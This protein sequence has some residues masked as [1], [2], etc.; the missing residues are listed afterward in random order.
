MKQFSLMLMVGM[1]ISLPPVSLS[2]QAQSSAPAEVGLLRDGDRVVLLGNAF[3]ER[4]QRF[5]YLETE[6]IR[7]A[8]QLDL[9]FRN[10][11]WSGDTVAGDAW[12]YSDS[13]PDHSIRAEVRT[14]LIREQ[15]PDVII[16]GFGGMEAFEGTGEVPSFRAGM[17]ELLDE[18]A[19]LNARVILMTSPPQDPKRSGNADRYNNSL[20]EYMNVVR[21]IA[22][23]RELPVIDL[24]QE[25]TRLYN[26]R[27][28]VHLSENGM[29][30][31]EQGYRE[32]SKLFG[33]AM[34]MP[35]APW[36]VSVDARWAEM[37]TVGTQPGEVEQDN[38]RLS[39]SVQDR[40][41][42]RS[43]GD[44]PLRSDPN[45]IFPSTRTLRITGLRDGRYTLYADGVEMLTASDK[46][47]EAGIDVNFG[48][49]FQ[50]AEQLRQ[51]VIEKNR[52]F[53]NQWRP[54][55]EVY[56]R[57]FRQREQGRNTVE[58]PLF[59]PLIGKKESDIARLK[60]AER[61]FYHLIPAAP[62]SRRGPETVPDPAVEKELATFNVAEGFEVT[63]FASEPLIQNPISINWDAQGRLWVS[64]SPIYPMIKPGQK[65]S[66]K[67]VIL[68]DLDQDGRADQST[69]FADGL[70]VPTAVLPGDGGAYVANS[71]ELLHMRDT[72]GDGK[73]DESRVILSGFGTEDTHQILHTF[74]RGP[75]GQMYFN[76]SVLIHS[77]IE[78]PWG[79]KHLDG[80]GIWQFDSKE[81][82]LDVYT[83]G[84]VNPWGMQF[85]RWGQ[86]FATD[87]AHGEGIYYAFPGAA[88]FWAA[89]VERILIGMNPGQPKECGLEILSG[90]AIPDAWQGRLVTSDFRAH[91]L[92]S[93]ELSDSGSGYFSEQKE[94]LLTSDHVGF[95]PVDL[96]MGPDGALY[97]CD[98]YNPIINHGEVDFRDPRRDTQH[99][100]I[101][102]I[103]AKDRDA[104]PNPNL[105]NADANQLVKSLASP[106][107]WTRDMA[108]RQLREMNREEVVKAVENW[109]TSTDQNGLESGHKRLEALWVYQSQQAVPTDFLKELL[110]ISD[111]RIRAASVRVLSETRDEHA[112]S[113]ALLADAVIDEHP[114]VRLEAVNALRAVGTLPAF[115]T[116]LHALD[117]PVDTY[118]DYAL[119]TTVREL[120]PVWLPALEAGRTNFGGDAARIAFVLSASGK[121]TVLDPL[122]ERYQ[123]G[124]LDGRI[125]DQV[126]RLM[127]IAGTPEQLRLLFDEAMA[128]ED[129]ATRDRL[130]NL[131]ID[132][133]R[134]RSMQPSGE[135]QSLTD[136]LE[137]SQA[138][139][140]L[141]GM[142]QLEPARE[143]VTSLARNA[144]GSPGMQSAAIAA[145]ARFGGENSAETLASLVK[146][147]QPDEIRA[148]ALTA[149]TS[150]NVQQA[151]EMATSLLAEMPPATAETVFDAFLGQSTG[152]QALATALSGKRIPESTASI[153][154]NKSASLGERTTVLVEALRTAGGQGRSRAELG[155]DAIAELMKQ[156]TSQGDPHRGEQ[157]Y[158]RE[159]MNCLKCH[160][161]GGAGGRVGP[162]MLSLGASAPLDY[163][164]ESLINPSAKIKES[165]E[166][167]LVLLDDGQVLSGMVVG[168]VGDHFL[169]RDANNVVKKV[170][171]DSVDQKVTQPV[172]LM[173]PGL[174]DPLTDAEFV[175]LVRFLSELGKTPDFKVP[176]VETVRVWQ[177]LSS[178]EP[179]PSASALHG[180][181][182]PGVWQTTYSLVRGPLPLANLSRVQIGGESAV[183]VRFGVDV[184]QAGQVQWNI[185]GTSAATV[186]ATID[187]KQIDISGG[188]IRTELT[189]GPHEV[190][191]VIP[192]KNAGEFL[193]I[194]RREVPGSTAQTTFQLE[195]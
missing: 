56:L 18:L 179:I 111:F 34:G 36:E 13:H 47:L 74:L 189:A 158:R 166:T 5:G 141:A 29:H 132:A 123:A 49:A 67:I 75:G 31:T 162:D 17:N 125:R 10:L 55:N 63:L 135:L 190:V 194:E 101:W 195:L 98:W 20:L 119:W 26:D 68:E 148:Q 51:A 152:P 50:R 147:D 92:V 176:A 40:F 188:S 93:F 45:V 150:L 58:L 9:T 80:G 170:A 154:I 164:V 138:A 105:A 64:T 91:R 129:A 122:I 156:A 62:A 159:A 106:E 46:E 139:V 140:T 24:H 61:T 19:P 69:V 53:F 187:G 163:I 193:Q 65:P 25:V 160:S 157:I 112:D 178:N 28:E 66:D 57:G 171:N 151:A 39:F 165:Y 37:T 11:S 161:I 7:R 86:S 130:F 15:K 168:E 21:D 30:F 84:L 73:A 87:G 85:D 48:P 32:L 79:P 177:V 77:H 14:R 114:R 155:P 113:F 185:G 59:D 142:W 117:H 104:L 52:L 191:L 186:S 109:L 145:L 103:A 35:S 42:P 81:Q 175:D 33:D 131:L 181:S 22:A 133:A 128:T 116:A 23:K 143:K 44:D 76:Q 60:H 149:L 183:V 180:Q 108:R 38:Q 153:G 126:T 124:D 27:P 110:E 8:P 107:K 136:Q 95:R 100:R 167:T 16:I 2:V 96:K 184:H 137:E 172:S 1:L 78:T 115:E 121:T 120:E 146:S 72:N 173:P 70:L 169:L 144:A 118:L 82:K 41:V 71:T 174:T 54:A 89:G 182:N 127:S 88:Y 134:D 97:V 102:R 192:E 83:R 4:A 99:G 43:W 90:R 6:L 94:D 12:S 3:L